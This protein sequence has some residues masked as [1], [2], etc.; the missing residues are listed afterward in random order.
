MD[1]ALDHDSPWKETLDRFL[2][3]FLE[4]TFP[5]IAGRI[6]WSVDPV[7]LEQELREIVPNAEPGP[8][9]ADKLVKVRLLDASS[10]TAA[11][12]TVATT[13]RFCPW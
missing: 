9:R 10:T 6:D 8:L 5:K 2:Q 13:S 3:P 12:T 11:A 7:L 1:D 4:L